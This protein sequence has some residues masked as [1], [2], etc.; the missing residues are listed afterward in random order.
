LHLIS[1][2]CIM[3]LLAELTRFIKEFR[4]G[5]TSEPPYPL[6]YDEWEGIQ[7]DCLKQEENVAMTKLLTQAQVLTAP[8]G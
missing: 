3:R 6:T 4:Q 1:S 8:L 7:Q 5:G 2:T